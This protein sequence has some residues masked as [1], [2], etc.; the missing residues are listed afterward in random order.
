MQETDIIPE[1]LTNLMVLTYFKGY[2]SI[3]K[4]FMNNKKLRLFH[5]SSMSTDL[6][7]ILQRRLKYLTHFLLNSGL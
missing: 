4:M 1:H 7:L 6:Q 5:L 3:F 2:W